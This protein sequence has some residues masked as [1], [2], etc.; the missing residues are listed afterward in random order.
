M[1]RPS[2]VVVVGGGI[3]GLAA[4]RPAAR[5]RP[6]RRGHRAASR[7]AGVG[8]KLRT[9]RARRAPVDVGAEAML[10]RRPEASRRVRWPRLGLADDAR[11]PA[12]RRRGGCAIAATLRPLPARH[13]DG[14]PGRPATPGARR[15]LLA[16]RG[17][18]RSAGPR[19]AAAGRSARTSS[20]GAL[21][22]ERLGDEVVDRLVEPL[23]GGVYAGRADELSLRAR[24]C[25]RWPRAA[26]RRA[27]RSVARGRAAAQAAR[28]APRPAARS[29]PRSPAG[30][31]GCSSAVGGGRAAR[32]SARAPTVR[33]LRRAPAGWRLDRRAGAATPSSVDADA[34]VLAVPAAPAARLLRRRRARGGRPS[35]ARIEYASVALVTLA[36][37]GRRRCRSCPGFLVPPVEGWTVKAVDV[38]HHASGPA[39]AA[40]AT[41]WP[42]RAR[43]GRPAPARGAAA[44]HRRRPGRRWRRPTCRAAA[45]R[46]AADAGRRGT[47]TRWGG[48]L[49]Q[50]A[51]RAPRPG[52]AGPGGAARRVPGA[53]GGGAAY[54]GVGIPACVALR[55]DGGR[56]RC[57]RAGTAKDAAWHDRAD[58]TR[59]RPRELN[60]D[61]PLHDVVGVPGRRSPLAD[62]DRAERRRRGRGA[63]RP[64]GRARTSWSAGTYD[65]AGL[66]ADADLM[67]WWHAATADALQEAYARFRRTALGRAL[68]AGLVA[69]GAAPPGRVQQEP[70]PGVPGRRGAAR[71]RL[72]LPVRALVRVVPAA[73]RGAARRC[74][75]STARWPAAT[76]TCGPTRWP[77]S[78]SATTSGCSRSR[79]TS[80]TASST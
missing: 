18:A 9:V 1:A 75:P 33:E 78:R 36:L 35:S 73:R 71:L 47:C 62:A 66:R 68:R 26:A 22:R 31:A 45:R 25:R 69:D 38:L 20:V 17:L 12:D 40:A 80:C 3:A 67:I 48:G 46:D 64:A 57:C 41:G 24:R 70:H 21:V 61:H 14:R 76:R 49:P 39:P 52:G 23:L 74:S 72:R 11:A 30:S 13:A 56:P 51:R 37:P 8:G 77:R 55:R 65:V 19:A 43:L 63:V 44:A 42:L 6:G 29:S 34:V 58:A 10:A 60:D 79:P 59:R 5:P 28:A 15:S 50:Y 27:T 16:G 32:R 4:A 53:G 54:D 2:R 7:P